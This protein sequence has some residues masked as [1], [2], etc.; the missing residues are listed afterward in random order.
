MLLYEISLKTYRSI[1]WLSSLTSAV[2]GVSRA[3]RTHLLVL[4][5]AGQRA[6]L[7]QRSPAAAAVTAAL[8]LGD[9]VSVSGRL[10]AHRLQDL[11]E[12]EA[13]PVICQQ[14]VPG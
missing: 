5:G 6:E 12:T 2:G 3:E 7:T 1:F 9:G 14:Q 4:Y 10:L 11:R 13:L 8:R